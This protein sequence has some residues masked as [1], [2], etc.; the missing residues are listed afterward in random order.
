MGHNFVQDF[1]GLLLLDRGFCL[2]MGRLWWRKRIRA[3]IANQDVTSVDLFL[4]L[5]VLCFGLALFQLDDVET[6]L[7]LYDVADFTR[8]QRVS[9]LFKFR[10]HVAMAKPA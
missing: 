5:P 2:V 1:L 4:W 3:C 10:H 7:A 9:S 8:L 6:K